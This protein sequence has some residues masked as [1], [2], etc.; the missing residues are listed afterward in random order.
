MS[1]RLRLRPGA[2][3]WREVEGE[4]VAL[5]LR[6]SV[7]LAVTKSGALLWPALLKGTSHRELVTRLC[8]RFE[9]EEDV[10]SADVDAFLG[11][12]TEHDLLEEV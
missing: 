10:A 9:I 8:E 2:L 5:D 11:E 12:L 3:E 4:I 6:R 1:N 7:Y